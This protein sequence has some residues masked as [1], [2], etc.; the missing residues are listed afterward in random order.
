MP[1]AATVLDPE[2]DEDE[3]IRRSWGRN[4]DEQIKTLQM[5]N[6][7]VA[8]AMKALGSEVSVQIVGQWRL[9]NKA[10]TPANMV[11]LATVLR[12]APRVL[13]SLDVI[14]LGSAA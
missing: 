6:K 7:S 4:I 3:A 10:P 9:G 5:T 8:T 2:L 13:F 12:V 14:R 1:T 11:A